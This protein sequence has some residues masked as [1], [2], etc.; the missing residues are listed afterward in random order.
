MPD[1]MIRPYTSA[2]N[3]GLAV[4]WNESDD[5]W[6]GTFT[7]GVPMTAEIVQD[8]ME[9]ETCLMRFVVE[10][11]TNDSIV[12]YG[13]LW[14]SPGRKNSCYVA[15]LNV[16]PAHQGRS[17]ARR[18]LTRMVDWATSHGYHRMTI[19]TWPGNLK[20][21]PLY[22][23]VGFFWVPDTDVYMENYIPAIRRLPVAQRFFERHDWYTTFR[24]DLKQVEDEQRHPATGDM[25]V[26]VFRWEEDGE[27]LEV[28]VDRR[29]QAITGL[30]TEH[31][32]AYAVVDEGEPAR[33]ITYP[34][35]WR[36]VNKRDE[37]VS[38]SVLADGEPDI[39]LGHRAS[40]DLD[41]GEER[42]VEAAF[43]CAV[44]APRLDPDDKRKPA[45]KIRTALVIGGDVVELATGLRH[46][47]AVTVGTEP[48]IPSLLPGR[49][50]VVHL[51]LQNRAG[52]P[53]SGTV[54]I[55]PQVGLTIEWQC[56][57]FELAADGYAGL[58]L[59]VT[60]D[61]AG[62]VPLVVTVAFV[63]GGRQVTAAPQ[64]IPLL[65]T[66][67]GGISADQDE[68]KIVAEND[69]FQVICRKKGGVCQ[70]RSKARQRRD[71][72]VKEELGPPF[73]PWDLSERRYN[74][75]LKQGRGWAQVA[76][77][78]KSD[79]FPGLTITR[80]I[81]LTGSP[82]IRVQHRV[83]NGSARPYKVQV[84]PRLW[85]ADKDASHVALPRKARLVTERASEF[86]ATE[87]DMPRSRSSWLSNGWLSAA[88]VR[89][90]A[91]SGARMWWS[92]SSGGR[93]FISTLLSARWSRGALPTLDHSTCTVVQV[94]GE[95][96]VVPGGEQ[97]V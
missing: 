43:T 90:L 8:W 10:D 7:G 17:L 27:F 62:A 53:L 46:R 32:A 83:V 82:L 88:M 26:Y 30:E 20:S 63:Y 38:V 2:D 94:V 22:K 69:F 78:A 64:R 34:V 81:A 3:T 72:S 35:R 97:W 15:L 37:S 61:Q 41:A 66:P 40:F 45:P 14:E 75:A 59:T 18:M 13:S 21:V 55:S 23:K 29:G 39:E 79:R 76:L 9:K 91:L 51:Q 68:D 93:V 44:D 4:M 80:E 86:P 71:M 87:G 5:Q 92:T 85:L 84:R 96:S 24:R 89:F 47:S 50:R 16:H 57:E 6:P 19:E 11:E 67:V 36:V 58:P 25:K 48:E 49:P 33:G 12:G 52:C 31:F 73:E 1:Y 74:L 77:T 28:V 42:V 95:T 60:C 70:L 56:R 65:S 54:S